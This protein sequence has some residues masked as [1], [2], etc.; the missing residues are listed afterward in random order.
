MTDALQRSYR[1][2]SQEV[3]LPSSL[4]AY[5]PPD[6][7][8]P[9]NS[10]S[11]LEALAATVIP[12][13]LMTLSGGA[14][15][16]KQASTPSGDGYYGPNAVVRDWTMQ[17]RGCPTL[18]T[19]TQI[20]DF[21]DMIASIA[22]SDGVNEGLNA[23]GGEIAWG[24]GGG[25]DRSML[26]IDNQFEFVDMVYSHFLKT[27]SATK[28]TE[29]ESTLLAAYNATHH[30]TVQNHLVFIDPDTFGGHV[31]EW[32]FWDSW[33]VRG[34]A[35]MT[36]VMR[37]RATVQIAEMLTA[38]GRTSDA[39]PYTA[40]AAAIKA[41]IGTYLYDSASGLLKFGTLGG[42]QQKSPIASAYAVVCGAVD[43][44]ISDA[45]STAL[46]NRLPGGS[47][48]SDGCFLHGQ[49][50]DTC[51]TDHDLAGGGPSMDGSYQAGGYWAV[52]TGWAAQAIKRLFPSAANTFMDSWASETQRQASGAPYEYA[53]LGGGSGS[54]Q[55]G[56]S[57]ALPLQYFS[58]TFNR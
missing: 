38:L 57:A 17:V 4:A 30:F 47:L 43:D 52:A 5:R 19:A 51:F 18:F 22:G 11:I 39:A 25:S 41:A 34:Y 33:D 40:E 9:V 42:N 36:S 6:P 55:Y 23:S 32:G 29:L 20:G 31:V 48:V 16:G 50:R 2:P 53:T 46:Y 13:S 49:V 27:G 58:S 15:A 45:I 44:T 14:F 37:Y 28:F 54:H 7:T 21:C 26:P 3:A 8:A 12:A 35:S 56:A 10:Q 1:S 24:G